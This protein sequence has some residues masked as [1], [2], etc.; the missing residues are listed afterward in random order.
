MDPPSLVAEI[1]LQE[2]T[3]REKATKIAAR[4]SAARRRWSIDCFGVDKADPALYDLTIK[5]SQI[6]L[7][8]AVEIIAAA[9]GDRAFQPMTYSQKVLHDLWLEARGEDRRRHSFPVGNGRASRRHPDHHHGRHRTRAERACRNHSR[10]V[11]RG[12]R[13]R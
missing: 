8:Q 13:G 1:A 5:L 4:R 7:E 12:S 9:A 3:T 2:K 6:G 11:D 10:A